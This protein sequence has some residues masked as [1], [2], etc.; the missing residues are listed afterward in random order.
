MR[1]IPFVPSRITASQTFKLQASM[2]FNAVKTIHIPLVL[3][4]EIPRVR[5]FQEPCVAVSSK[6]AP[7]DS[8]KMLCSKMTLAKDTRS[9]KKYFDYSF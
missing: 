5:G 2:P 3:L 7:L 6:A 9:R 8:R 1:L 4:P